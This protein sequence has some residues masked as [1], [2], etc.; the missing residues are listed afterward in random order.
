MENKSIY[1]LELKDVW[2]R[3]DTEW[4]LREINL[5]LEHDK[6]LG[7]IGPNG[8]GKTT[9]IKLIAGLESPDRG[10]ILSKGFPINNSRHAPVIGYVPQS[11]TVRW[12]FPIKVR[13]VILLGMKSQVKLFSK[14][15]DEDKEHLNKLVT[16]IGINNLLD[17]HISEL[18]GGQQ[19][20]VFIARA[21]INDPDLLLLDEPQTG[22]DV[23]AQDIFFSALNDIREE[24][25]LTIIL[26]TH[27]LNIVPKICDEVACVNGTMFHHSSPAEALTCPNFD[28]H[29]G[30]HLEVLI[31]GSNIPHRLVP[32]HKH[33]EESKDNP[34]G[35]DNN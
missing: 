29:F 22:I 33:D 31:H 32:Y 3:Y 24:F 12:T 5:K 9:L 30:S 10:E 28:K 21:M 25:N 17:K 13:D 26:V 23:S 4:I 15:R 14:L 19:Q 8:G 20:K 35:E 18:S 34:E 11:A 7:I 27:D 2:F 6:V 16:S 1:I